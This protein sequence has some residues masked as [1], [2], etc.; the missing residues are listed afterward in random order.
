[1]EGSG[2][3]FGSVQNNYGS[4]SGRPKNT[5]IYLLL[6]IHD[7]DHWSEAC[8]F[9]NLSYISLFLQFIYNCCVAEL[10][11]IRQKGPAIPAAYSRW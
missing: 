1:M 5:G 7:T 4:G 11:E 8:L 2:S 6:R 10:F 3:R 9:L